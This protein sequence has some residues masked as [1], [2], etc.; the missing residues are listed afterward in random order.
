M[1]DLARK[2]L[3]HDKTRFAVTVMGVA[4]AVALETISEPTPVQFRTW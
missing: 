3:L 2:I 1:V 4:F